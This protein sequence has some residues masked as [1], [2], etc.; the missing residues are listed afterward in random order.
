LLERKLDALPAKL[1]GGISEKELL[2]G[3]REAEKRAEGKLDRILR[4]NSQQAKR[5]REVGALLR[6]VAAAANGR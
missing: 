5:L 1:R 2:R 6:E 4:E 3:D